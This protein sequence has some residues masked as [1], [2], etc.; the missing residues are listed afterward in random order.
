MIHILIFILLIPFIG[1]LIKNIG[2]TPTFI[3]ISV[4][5][6][7]PVIGNVKIFSCR[8]IIINWLEQ[9]S[10][11][12][13]KAQ[14]IFYAFSFKLDFTSFNSIKIKVKAID[15]N[16]KE[17]IFWFLFGNCFLGM[18]SNKVKILDNDLKLIWRG[19]SKQ[20]KLPSDA[21]SPTE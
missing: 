14:L 20:L 10:L 7:L 15:V 19:N 13:Q 6:G 12:L 11:D 2:F 5:F 18:W 16:G 1:W 3:L 9:Q 17:R 4:F 21:S 8:R